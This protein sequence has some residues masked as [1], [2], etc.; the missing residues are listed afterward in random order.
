MMYDVF[1]FIIK[2]GNQLS[3]TLEL[4]DNHYE[5]CEVL[6]DIRDQLQDCNPKGRLEEIG[7]FFQLIHPFKSMSWKWFTHY[8]AIYIICREVC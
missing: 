1:G 2:I 4:V 6:L 7:I 8:P 3:A 5:V